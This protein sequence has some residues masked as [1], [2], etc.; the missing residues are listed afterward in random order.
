MRVVLD[1]CVVVAALRSRRGASHEVLRRLGGDRFEIAV[2]VPLVLEYTEV[3]LRQSKA[4]G[5]THEDISDLI[6]YLCS[7]S[8][9]QQVFFLW[10][11]Q[12]PD[13]DDDAV[14]E[15][16]ANAGCKAI[17]THNVRDFVGS[18]RFG[19]MVMTPGEFLKQLR[20]EQ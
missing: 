11:P 5:L 10:R 15:L 8:V 20:G 1:T 2:S 13:P 14:L 17:V 6:D 18:E 3:L 16:A 4:L 9:H 12:L 19:V 7:V